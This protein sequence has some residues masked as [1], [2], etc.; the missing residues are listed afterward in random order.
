MQWI[1]SWIMTAVNL[2]NRVRS[3]NEVLTDEL[4][5]RNHGLVRSYLIQS[6]VRIGQGPISDSRT[7][8]QKQFKG[9]FACVPYSSF[10]LI[11]KGSRTRQ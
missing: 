7:F 10:W 3:N 4:N 5:A 6:G 2:S 1:L 9:K 8:Y 11:K